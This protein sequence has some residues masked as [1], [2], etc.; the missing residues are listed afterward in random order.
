MLYIRDIQALKTMLGVV[1]REIREC[2]SATTKPNLSEEIK[3]A[4]VLCIGELLK[5]SS[6][7]VLEMYYT[8]ESSLFLGQVLLTLVEF[9]ST[10]KFR[11]LV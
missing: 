2:N 10:E 1:L 9:I 4:A 3:L 7:D 5:R 6:T 11:K 8:K